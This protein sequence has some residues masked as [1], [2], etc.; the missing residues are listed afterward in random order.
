MV[1]L[2]IARRHSLRRRVSTPRRN[3]RHGPRARHASRQHADHDARA[4]N[5]ELPQ[6]ELRLVETAWA[7]GQ[8][9]LERRRTPHERTLRHERARP[10]CFASDAS[11]TAI[12]RLRPS[13]TQGVSRDRGQAG[14]ACTRTAFPFLPHELNGA[15]CQ[16]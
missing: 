2:R 5:D 6:P 15:A 12:A 10:R 4:L 13:I 3:P 9:E 14:S 16:W 7:S 1:T 11:A 8:S